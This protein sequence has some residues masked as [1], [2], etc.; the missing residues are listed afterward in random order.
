MNITR[1]IRMY[2]EKPNRDEYPVAVAIN[3]KYIV[4]SREYMQL[5]EQ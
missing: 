1:M 5:K 2:L 3:D 4:F